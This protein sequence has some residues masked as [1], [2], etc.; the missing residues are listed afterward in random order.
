VRSVL[1][2]PLLVRARLVGV[3][4]AFN[5]RAGGGPTD[6]AAAFN[7]E[8]ERLL[9][10]IASQSAQVLE[11]ARLAEGERELLRMQEQL[12]LAAD[13]QAR[14]LPSA[15]PEVLGYDVAGWSLSSEAVGGDYFDFIPLEDGRLGFAVGD[16][17]GKGLPA[18]LL[19]AN[20]RATLRGQASGSNAAA[21]LERANA[22]LH[23]STSRR[24]F[25]TLFYGVLDPVRHRVRYANAG[26]NRPLLLATGKA[27][28]R[29][30]TG[31]LALGMVSSCAY[32]EAEVAIGPGDLLFVY[33]DGVTEAMDAD[34]EEF[35]E[36]RLAAVLEGCRD[37]PAS[38]LSNVWPRPSAT[39]PAVP[40][41]RTT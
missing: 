4:T 8:D 26:H 13:L 36:A 14:L 41:S 33:S 12:R 2:V 6:G 30:E 19:M 18:A 16:V 7:A 17:V 10:I 34:R 11:N 15:P 28:A 25:V 38:T 37:A 31:G 3:L 40:R 22:L 23:G 9:A 5:K 21:C 29:L 32:E 27:P 39:T 24:E 1:C 20:V 35:G